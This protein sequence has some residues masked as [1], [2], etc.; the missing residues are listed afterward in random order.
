MAAAHNEDQVLLHPA[1]FTW[2][3]LC[4]LVFCRRKSGVSFWDCI[5][6]RQSGLW[7]G[8]DSPR[9]HPPGRLSNFSQKSRGRGDGIT[10]REVHA[11]SRGGRGGFLDK[12]ALLPYKASP[13]SN[14]SPT[15]VKYHPPEAQQQL[16][17]A[18]LHFPP[19]TSFLTPSTSQRQE[20]SE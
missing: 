4:C 20:A 6:G 19:S 10:T 7:G 5:L 2:D 16:T 17:Q 8:V 13:A 1:A 15:H 9:R 3:R 11:S 18:T 12:G 14:I